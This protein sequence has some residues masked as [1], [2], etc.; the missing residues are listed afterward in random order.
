MRV[1]APE[2]PGIRKKYAAQG[3]PVPMF[4]RSLVPDSHMPDVKHVETRRQKWS[5]H[6]HEFIRR[7]RNTMCADLDKAVDSLY[8]LYRAAPLLISDSVY[9][10]TDLSRA[11]ILVVLDVLDCWTRYLPTSVQVHNSDIICLSTTTSHTF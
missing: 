7:V 4:L 5:I 2:I 10:L 8:P 11:I 3:G 1:P 9:T 6:L